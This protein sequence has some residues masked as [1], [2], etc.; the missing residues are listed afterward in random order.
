MQGL[1]TAARSITGIRFAVSIMFSAAMTASCTSVAA[2]S[3][4][5][6]AESAH[7]PA[8]AAACEALGKLNLE[9]IADHPAV[10]QS[11][12]YVTDAEKSLTSQ[13]MFGKRSIV[14]GHYV[15]EDVTELPAHCRIEGYV[16]PATQFLLLLP[17]P[18]AWNDKV[19]YGSC[20]AFCGAVE[21]D[22]PVMPLLRGYASITT[23][24][25]HIN[26]RPFDGVWG[27]KNREAEIDFSHRA[28]HFAAQISKALSKAYYGRD[29]EHAYIVGF[30][31]GGHA[32]IKSALEYPDDYDG[33][34]SR[35]P[36]V[37][38][39]GIN[40]LRMPYLVKTNQRADGSFILHA[41]DAR[42]LHKGAI[43]HCAAKD[44]LDDGMIED[45]RN[46]DFDPESLLCEAD[47]GGT[48]CL[49]AEKVDV[50]KRFYSRPTSEDG[51]LVWPYPLEYGSELNWVGFHVPLTPGAEP[52]A[53]SIARTYLRYIAF[54]T[55]P[56]PQYDWTIFD[57]AKDAHRLDALKPII[58]ADDPNLGAFRD[59][60]GKMIVLHGWADGAISA[61]S[62]LDWYESVLTEMGREAVPSFARLFLL[63]G[64][65][66]GASSGGGPTINNALDALENWVENGVAPNAIMMTRETDGIV[67]WSRPVFAYPQVARYSGS[68]SIF[69]AENFAPVLP[70]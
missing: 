23:N 55:D 49:T 70:E 60:G 61:Q 42:L 26:K 4:T 38:Y 29:A 8:Q 37:K 33:V 54:E 64:S 13:F 11:A 51:T 36:T 25:G 24:G 2:P 6:S 65:T 17:E 62:S 53:A 44:G 32:G 21:E 47:Q 14:Q 15:G 46:C 3:A 48:E 56:G 19:L 34:V 67:D 5:P 27:Y 63:P 69:D 10:I 45:P 50:A 52:Y 22:I 31:K 41:D 18:A 12:A 68:G 7:K 16:A 66:H 39:Q 30:S 43:A 20:D 40:A 58:D 9:Q 28:S 1:S 59:S 57:T 35:A